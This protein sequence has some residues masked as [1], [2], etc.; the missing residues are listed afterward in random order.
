M[1]IPTENVEDLIE[2]LGGLPTRTPHSKG[3]LKKMGCRNG[4]NNLYDSPKW[5]KPYRSTQRS[6]K[7]YRRNQYHA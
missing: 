4:K 1:S 3:I 7:K 6:W 5:E 2:V